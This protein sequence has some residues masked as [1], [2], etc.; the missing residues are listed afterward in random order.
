MYD[1]PPEM[2]LQQ[3][4]APRH[5][6][7]LTID[8][9]RYDTYLK[10][11]P[12]TRAFA[13][14]SVDFSAAYSAGAA[15]YWSIPALL[16]SRPPSF[17]KM[18]RDQT[19]VKQERLLTEALKDQ[20]F[21]TGLFANVTIFF[22]RGLS[23][24]AMTK[25]YQTSRYTV[26]GAR[27]G[28]Q[29]LTDSLIKHLD[30]WRDHKLKPQRQRLFM[31]AHYYDPH[32]PYFEVPNYPAES[33]SAEHRYEAIVRSVDAELGRLF[34]ALEERG[35]MS[36]T[37]V[38]LTADHG[39]E[40]GEHGHRFH[41]RT[42]YDE[43]VRVPLIIYSPSYPPQKV[44]TVISHLDVAPTLL[45][46]LGLKPERRFLGLDWDHVLRRGRTHRRGE[47]IFEVLPDSNY[48]RHLIGMR[49]GNEKLIYHAQS[50][51]IERYLL[52]QDPHDLLNRHL[53]KMES[54][55]P[56]QSKTRLMNY[57]ETHLRQLARRE[58]GARFPRPQ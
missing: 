41:G 3:A 20:G 35:M 54:D 9:L 27:P 16:G 49:R 5:L 58:S 50:G 47:A 36:N 31:W 43:M 1:G 2:A 21:H 45:S 8:A 17:F 44:S 25:N 37:A 52:D 6:I 11:M 12:E 32:D 19:P 28:A 7:L 4:R 53:N 14:K 57:V 38:V 48:G 56:S 13:K 51:G 39:D 33:S 22:V 18:G 10:H 30:A 24:G 29:H 23:Q 34:Q 42:L 40:F 26:H 15:T 55:Q 46:H